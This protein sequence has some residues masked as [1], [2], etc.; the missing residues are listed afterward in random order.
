MLFQHMI[1]LGSEP[2]SS[3]SYRSTSDLVMCER[4]VVERGGV[5]GSVLW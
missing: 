1:Y 5:R 4:P 3:A 2:V